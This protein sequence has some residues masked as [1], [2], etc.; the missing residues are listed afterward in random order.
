MG[1]REEFA[2][3][4][5]DVDPVTVV[6]RPQ[7]GVLLQT[8]LSEFVV[9]HAE[10][11]RRAE[12]RQRQ[13]GQQVR[14]RTDVVLVGVCRDDGVD[15]VSVL[16]QIRQI[17]EDGV[18]SREVVTT[19]HLAAIED[20][21]A[22]FGLDGRTVPAD[23]AEPAEERDR[24]RCGHPALSSDRGRQARPWLRSRRTPARAP[25]ADGSGQPAAP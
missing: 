17:R 3:E 25:S 15:P 12:D 18:D 24:D 9:D 19:E 21:D 10:G 13:V 16:D 6:H 8:P 14:Q 5:T 4:R 22:S 20:D 1:Y 2:V 11:E 23:L 7:L